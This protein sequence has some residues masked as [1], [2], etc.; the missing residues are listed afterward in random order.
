MALSLARL[1]PE[2]TRE[3]ACRA[4]VIHVT[5]YRSFPTGVTAS[6]SKRAEYL[7]AA[8]K[9]GAYIVEDDYESEFSLSSKTADTIFANDKNDCVIY[10]NTFSKT[11]SPAL[12]VGYML[13]PERLVGDFNEKLGFYSCSVPVLEQFLI[14]KL[15]NDGSFERHLNRVRRARKKQNSGEKQ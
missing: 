9:I 8:K 7:R 3:A 2:P 11:I 15:L 10:V 12:R 5:P 1:V 4:R 6:A 13:I 14:A